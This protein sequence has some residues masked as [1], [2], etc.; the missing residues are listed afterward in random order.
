VS[1]IYLGIYFWKQQI[2][3]N[4]QDFFKEAPVIKKSN[5]VKIEF[6]RNIGIISRHLIGSHKEISMFSIEARGSGKN[7]KYNRKREDRRHV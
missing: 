3:L 7:F 5:F 1:A 2:N 4:K 6:Y